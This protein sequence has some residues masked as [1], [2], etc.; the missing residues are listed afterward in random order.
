MLAVL[1][2]KGAQ[3]RIKDLPV[4]LFAVHL[5]GD[6]H[7]LHKVQHTALG[8]TAGLHLLEAVGHNGQR[9]HLGKLPQ[10]IQHFRPHQVRVG[11]ELFQIEAVHLGSVTGGINGLEEAGEPLRH[12]LFPLELAF[13]QLPPQLRV[14]GAVGLHRFCVRLNAVVHQRFGQC[15]AFGCV[16]VQQGIVCIEQDAII[17]CHKP[18]LFSFCHGLS[19]HALNNR[20]KPALP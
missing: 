7:V 9:C 2:A 13:F 17:F 19:C 18:S 11:G 10:H 16:K 8:Q 15:L 6:E 5:L 14:D 4:R 1:H 3:G 20:Q 12:E